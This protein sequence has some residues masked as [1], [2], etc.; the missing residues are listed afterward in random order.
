MEAVGQQMITT[1]QPQRVRVRITALS[2]AKL[3]AAMMDSPMSVQELADEVG[4]AV[5]TVRGYVHAM[6]REKVCRIGGWECYSRGRTACFIMG[7]G[8]DAPRPKAKS[9]ALASAEWRSRRKQASLLG[10]ARESA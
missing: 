8:P 2:F 7:R 9:R 6:H 5:K 10:I 4:L 1:T 3:V